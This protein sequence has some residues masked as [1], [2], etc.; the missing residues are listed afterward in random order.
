MPLTTRCNHCGR[1][2]PVYAQQLKR[3]R[4]KVECPQCGER[5]DDLSGLIDEVLPGTAAAAAGRSGAAHRSQTQTAPASL[6]SFDETRRRPGRI[7]AAL[8]I[9][10]ILLLSA[11]LV[12]QL[13]WWERGNWLRYAWVN[14]LYGR[15]CSGHTLCP[16]LPRYA[17]SVEILQPALSEHPLDP[18]VLRLA[19][20][21]V[22]NSRQPQR[23]PDIQLELYDEQRMPIAARRFSPSDYLPAPAASPVLA[24][25]RAMNVALEIASPPIPPA[26]FRIRLY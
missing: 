13:F 14:D 21:L 11:V 16:P 12:L 3:R 5:F 6:M 19:L 18:D 23:A 10:G 15:A 17:G 7:R 20:T 24:A 8:W 1:L 22:S 9:L 4:G 26:G 25:G 2:F